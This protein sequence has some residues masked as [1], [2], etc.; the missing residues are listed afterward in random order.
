MGSG[1]SGHQVTFNLILEELIDTNS[2]KINWISF[3]A[4]GHRQRESSEVETVEVPS[5]NRKKVMGLEMPR[6]K[7]KWREKEAAI[8][9][10]CGFSPCSQS[11]DHAIP[12]WLLILVLLSLSLLL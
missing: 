8:L 11:P 10:K 12:L 9:G 7:T 5:S 1:G 6:M 3:L 4:R 2:V